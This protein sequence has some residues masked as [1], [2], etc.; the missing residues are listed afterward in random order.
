MTIRR[1]VT[2]H[3]PSGKAT[4]AS[5]ALV[6]PDAIPELGFQFI[7]L[8]GADVPQ[9]FP[10]S[11]QVPEYK[12]YFPPRMGYR[13]GIFTIPPGRQSPLPTEVRVAAFQRME[14]LFPGLSSHMEPAAPGMHTS[15]SVDFGYVLSGSI[16]LELDDGTERELR[17]G[18]TYV[19]NGTRHAWRNR[20]EQ[21]CSILVVL[22]G[23]KRN[24]S[25]RE[26]ARSSGLRA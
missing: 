21:P 1:V 5:D 2:G 16:C 25:G 12:D 20:T 8:W 19:Q 18:D 15:D 23:A 22:V 17:A 26:V 6:E 11:G 3:D 9:A 4:I 24:P 13:F 10:D 7:K 14:Q